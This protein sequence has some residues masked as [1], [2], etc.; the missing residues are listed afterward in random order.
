MTDPETQPGNDTVRVTL[1]KVERQ[2]IEFLSAT[3]KFDDL[4]VYVE[5]AIAREHAATGVQETG[6]GEIERMRPFVSYLAEGLGAAHLFKIHR[7]WPEPLFAIDRAI[8]TILV[9]TIDA[10]GN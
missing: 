3:S 7:S 8:G 10:R 4:E 2:D 1:T 6:P 9:R 5:L